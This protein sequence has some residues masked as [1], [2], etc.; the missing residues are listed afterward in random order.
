MVDILCIFGLFNPKERMK[1]IR[2]FGDINS[3]E[4]RWREEVDDCQGFQAGSR[5]NSSRGFQSHQ[6]TFERQ[7]PTRDSLDSKAVETFRK[8]VEKLQR[9]LVGE[10]QY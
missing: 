7:K 5:N 9:E 1:C 6:P 2:K 3:T 4:D 10:L 8:D